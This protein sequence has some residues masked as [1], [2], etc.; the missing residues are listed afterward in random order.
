MRWQSRFLN[1]FSRVAIPNITMYWIAF[2]ALCLILIWARQDFAG[3]LVFDADKVL[4]GEWWRAISFLFMPGELSPIWAAFALYFLWLMG[5][6][7]EGNWGTA[8]YNLYLLI[9]ALMTIATAFVPTLLGLHGGTGT[10]F[11]LLTSIFL[12]FAT[13]YPDFTVYVF[14]IFPVRIKWLALFTWI[15][16]G[17]SLV[18]ASWTGKAMLIASLA[19]YFLFFGKEIAQRARHGRKQ[20]ARQVKRMGALGPD[21]S[22]M[23]MHTCIVCSRTE[24]SHPQLEFRYC[25]DCGNKCYCLEHLRGHACTRASAHV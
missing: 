25:S 12:A 10:N 4:A 5:T 7:L 8:R 21:T 1:A 11:F 3:Q 18:I 13:L 22:G 20:M 2:Q 9:G 16:L 19:N 14:F 24:K 6:G 15:M 23:A 17:I